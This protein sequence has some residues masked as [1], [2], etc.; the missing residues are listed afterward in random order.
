MGPLANEEQFKSVLNH[1]AR[2]TNEGATVIV[3]GGQCE[4]GFPDEGYYVAP[5][6]LQGSSENICCREEI[7]G[8][9]AYLL[10]FS[11]DADAI[12]ITNALRY[13]L[14]NSVWSSDLSRANRVAE[15]LISGNTWINA[16]NV[17]AY[18]LPYGEVNQS[19]VGGGVNSPETYYDY[20]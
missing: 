12:A 10:K 4:A 5:T 1:L 8:P 6:L 13:G 17:F 14:A 7:F 18:G 2:G 15:Q 16:H 9:V 3:G 19:G 20:L 11:R